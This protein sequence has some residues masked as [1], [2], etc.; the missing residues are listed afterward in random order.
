MNRIWCY[1]QFLIEL[2]EGVGEDGD[3]NEVLNA[4]LLT[5]LFNNLPVTHM[6]KK[7]KFC[8]LALTACNFCLQFCCFSL[9]NTQMNS[10]EAPIYKGG[11]LPSYLFVRRKDPKE[12]ICT[13][14]SDKGVPYLD[15]IISPYDNASLTPM[16]SPFLSSEVETL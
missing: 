15:W 16:S 10:S 6:F 14:G 3:G 8:F 9:L 11:L 13:C 5:Q 4:M 1:H 7:A 2:N 12:F